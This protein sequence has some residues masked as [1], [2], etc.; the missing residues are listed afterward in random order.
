MKL[1]PL[2]GCSGNLLLPGRPKVIPETARAH[3]RHIRN[4]HHQSKQAHECMNEKCFSTRVGLQTNHR[5][6]NAPT[7]F[8]QTSANTSGDTVCLWKPVA[9]KANCKKQD[10]QIQVRLARGEH[11]T[12]G[13]AIKHATPRCESELTAKVTSAV[14]FF[15]KMAPHCGSRIWAGK[16][17][18]R[19]ALVLFFC[20]GG[21][22]PRN[23]GP[24]FDPTKWDH[25]HV[26]F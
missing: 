7:R 11:G 21:R 14:Q 15:R 10:T 18:P 1:Q 16:V 12:F 24:E 6:T 22:R 19:P 8:E 20:R 5:Q 26:K 25:K 2:S 9:H 13:A 4:D 23:P 3:R 17:G